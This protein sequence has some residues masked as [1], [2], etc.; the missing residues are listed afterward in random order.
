MTNLADLR[1]PAQTA[2]IRYDIPASFPGCLIAQ[3]VPKRENILQNA[4][5][6]EFPPAYMYRE[7]GLSI[8]P[9]RLSCIVRCPYSVGLLRLDY[10]RCLFLVRSFD[11]HM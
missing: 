8:S 9:G 11:M 5:G 2:V 10:M 4:Q 6:W 7:D 3:Y 1:R